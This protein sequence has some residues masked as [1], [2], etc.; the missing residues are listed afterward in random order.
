MMTMAILRRI[1]FALIGVAFI[2]VAF[3]GSA[4]LAATPSDGG[5]AAALQR[6]VDNQV[7][8]GAVVLVADKDKVLDLE[9]VGY[10]DITTHK[11]M[12]ADDL[13]YIASMTKCFTAAAMMMLVDEG[14]VNLDDPVEKY[15]PEFKGQLVEEPD[16]GGKSAGPHPPRHPISV[17][18][19]MNHTAGFEKDPK[20][21]RY[22]LE[23]EAKVMAGTRLQ[24]EPGMKFQYGSGLEIAGRIIEVVS[25]KPYGDFVRERL[26]DPLGMTS[27]TFWPNAEQA[28]HLALTHVVN[29]ETKMLEPMR[30]NQ[31]LVDDPSKCGT[32]PPIILSQFPASMI[33]TY[34]EHFARPS[35]GLFSTATAISKFCRML[36]GGGTFEG[37]K[38]LSPEAVKEMSSVQTSDLPVASKVQGYGF[39]LFVQRKQLEGGVSVGSFGHHGARKT[40]LWIDP[41]NGI[42]M[43]LMVQ[44]A[45][46]S[47]EQQTDLYGSY[48]KQAVA[49]YGKQNRHEPAGK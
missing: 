31:E 36:L 23:D 40:Q 15:L 34:A 10:S 8:A 3:I 11:P 42:C 21:R 43:V 29:A 18:Q 44:S 41:T 9:T 26:L 27:T 2:S 7:I 25:G 5:M 19:T 49:R 38:Y 47:G 28:S 39:G 48:Q 32:V 4:V 35:G 16:G 22:T 46:L 17:R 14:K 24:W 6:F 33:P 37:K 12:K 45:E 13:F 20:L 30:S 1:G